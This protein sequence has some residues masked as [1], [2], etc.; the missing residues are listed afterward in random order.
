M[1]YIKNNQDRFDEILLNINMDGAGY[2]EG[3][4]AFSFYGLPKEMEKEIR[5]VIS[6]FDGITVG[7]EWVQGDHSIFIQHG[8]P[9]VA[10]SS[11][12]FT[13]HIDS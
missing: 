8:C 7:S 9:A 4:S 12:W 1:L 2:T 11:Q 5:E 10:L 3:K 13:D 6:H